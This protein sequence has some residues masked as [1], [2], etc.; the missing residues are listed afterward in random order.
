[1]A[2]SVSLSCFRMDR[3]LVG[4]FQRD[5]SERFVFCYASQGKIAKQNNTE[6]FHIEMGIY[7]QP[8]LD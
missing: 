2:L 8:F 4:I 3:T 5:D 7:R 1:M 6:V